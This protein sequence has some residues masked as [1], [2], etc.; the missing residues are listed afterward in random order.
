MLSTATSIDAFSVGVVIGFLT[1]SIVM[2]I[3]VF[4]FVTFL[5]SFLGI[6]I[7]DK[8]GHMFG[9]RAQFVGGIILIF[10]GIKILLEHT[11]FA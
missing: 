5:L 4:G 8:L 6:F 7:G 3:L 10:I 1:T 9:R 11:V 2:P